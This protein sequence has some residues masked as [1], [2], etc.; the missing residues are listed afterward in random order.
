MHSLCQSYVAWMVAAADLHVR[1]LGLHPSCKGRARI[2][3]N[4]TFHNYHN[5]RV[6]Y[7]IQTNILLFD[8]RIGLYPVIRVRLSENIQRLHHNESL[9]MPVAMVTFTVD[10]VANHEPLSENRGS[11]PGICSGKGH[12]SIKVTFGH[13]SWD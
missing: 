7:L 3:M 4:R 2:Y 12:T 10:N 6:V 9:I 1:R 8:I 5:N 11:A 13:Y